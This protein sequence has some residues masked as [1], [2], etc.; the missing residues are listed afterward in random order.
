MGCRWEINQYLRS[1][2]PN[3][4]KI[5]RKYDIELECT[6]EIVTYKRISDYM[7]ERGEDAIPDGVTFWGLSAWY[8]SFTI[9]LWTME[10]GSCPFKYYGYRNRWDAE[11]DE[12]IEDLRGYYEGYFEPLLWA[13]SE[14]ETDVEDMDD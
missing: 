11:L 5:K 4:V 7:V 14:G 10:Y 9:R 13:G 2:H 8:S 1:P 6:R 3:A 12:E